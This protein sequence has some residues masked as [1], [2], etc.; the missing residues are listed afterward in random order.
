MNVDG[1]DGIELCDPVHKEAGNNGKVD[2][3]E[4]INMVIGRCSLFK[5]WNVGQVVGGG[6]T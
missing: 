6:G 5:K 2:W 1:D 4:A 3:H